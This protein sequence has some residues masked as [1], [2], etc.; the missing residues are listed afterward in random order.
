MGIDLSRFE[1]VQVDC[2]AKRH[3]IGV[4]EKAFLLFSVG[5]LNEN[6]N[7]QIVIRAM[8]KLGDRNIHYAIAGIGEKREYLLALARDLGVSE[9]LHLLGYRKDVAE[10][11]KTSDVFVFPSYREGLS[12]SLME[13]MA[14]SL[15]C[16]VSRIRGNTDLIDEN[17][18]KMFDPYDEKT[19]LCELSNLVSSDIKNM[20]I[21]NSTKIQK[22]SIEKVSEAMLEIYERSY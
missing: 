8:A 2:V 1:N 19:L 10:L 15:P 16:I 4:P 14:S 18:G 11:Y 12:V 9:Q 21:Q 13:A 7:H 6:K 20:G 22:F 3:E 17:G 5:E